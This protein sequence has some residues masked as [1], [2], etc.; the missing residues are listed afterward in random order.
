[1]HLE[2]H[3]LNPRG[4]RNLTFLKNPRSRKPQAHRQNT[5][6]AF[7]VISRAKNSTLREAGHALGERGVCAPVMRQTG[8]DGLFVRNFSL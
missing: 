1:M 4:I 6:T 7:S 3:T 2:Q 5:R 8:G